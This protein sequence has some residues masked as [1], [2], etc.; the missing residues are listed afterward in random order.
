VL[1]RAA[2]GDA[3][4]GAAVQRVGRS[5]GRGL[6]GIVNALDPEVV[7]LSG[8][9]VDLLATARPVIEDAYR[10]GLMAFRRRA[11]PPLR[12]AGFP[13]DGSLRGAAELAFDRVLCDAGLDDW[14]AAHTGRR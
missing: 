3:A 4:A 2:A 13:A 6:A 10:A 7:T 8:L 9:A 1:A 12:S 14:Q 5:L 11:A